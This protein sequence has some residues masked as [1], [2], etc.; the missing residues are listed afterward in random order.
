M[1]KKATV[2]EFTSYTFSPTKSRAVFY[3]A[4]YF[5]DKSVLHFSE[6]ILLPKPVST[7]KIPKELLEKILS[8]LHIILGISYYKFYCAPKISLPYQLS[9]GESEFWN[10]VYQNGLGEFFFQNKLDPKIS[11]TFPFKK[12]IVVTPTI[13]NPDKNYLVG[14]GG[15]KDSIV[16]AELLKQAGVNQT[17]FHVQAKESAIINQV[18]R[19]IDKPE[20]TIKRILDPKAFE[21][22][23]Y[24]GHVPVSAIYAFLGIFS[25]ILYGYKGMIVGNEYSSNFGNTDYKGMTINHQWSKSF[26][27][28][29]I[30]SNF[31]HQNLSPNLEYFS[32]L[33]SLYEIRIVEI[34]ANHPKYFSLF[35][36]CNQNFKI[37]EN[38][39]TLWCN[40]CPKCVF[41]FLLLSAFLPK[42]KV[43]AIFGK[44]LYQEENLLLLFKD[45]LGLGTMKPFDCVGTFSEAQS[46]LVLAKEKF[47]DDFMVRQLGNNVKFHPEVFKTNPEVLIP[48]HLRFLG[49]KNALIVGYGKE[50]TAT[51]KYLTNHFP[52]LAVT[53]ADAKDG[54][55]YLAYQENFDIAIKSPSVKPVEIKIPYTTATNI[56]FSQVLGKNIII[57][58]T[59]SKGKSTTTS[60]IF[61][62]LKTAG[63][64]AVLLGN[65][66]KPMLEYLQNTVSKKTVFVLELSSYQLNDIRYSPD[67]AVLTNLFPEHLDWHGSLASYYQAKKHIIDFQNPHQ[68]FVHNKKGKPW[69]KN[70]QGISVAFKPSNLKSNLLGEHN[71]SNVG[72]AV[73]VAEIL[74][75]KKPVIK[76]A[77]STFTGLSH[78]LENIGTLKGITFYDDAI[79]TTPDSTI[80]AIKALK[81]VDTIFLGGQDRGYDF[82]P[83]EKILKK[84]RIKNVVLF[85]DS[86]EKMI[87]DAQDFNILKTTKMSEAVA[88]AYQNTQKGK[89]CLLSCASPSYSLW[90]NFEE[91]GDQF[92]EEVIRQSS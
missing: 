83:L 45:V 85:P 77:V 24:N 71:Q 63:F 32:L 57:G 84:Y 14:I 4:T 21:K 3:Y 30:F 17:L 73:S 5:S 2:F 31:V 54:A 34:F 8:S 69:L 9:K 88:F 10:T 29:K 61:H 52:D 66:G 38:Q 27:F 79:S 49:M 47:S 86:G 50:G 91:K 65:I 75:I 6:E 37:K 7:K 55:N 16:V 68:Y 13:L 12:N 59:G 81:N 74:G 35:S 67:I 18:A 70:Y 19:V 40:Q 25:A 56:F 60:L 36:S 1:D 43:V 26:E 28:E 76:K 41:A 39:Q 46:A 87:K 44:N 89:I 72:A 82:T 92:K 80:E 51:E 42:E 15:G 22:H 53:I 78:R 62:I 20:F 90:K 64:D 58:V 48:E 33:R 23:L 11:P